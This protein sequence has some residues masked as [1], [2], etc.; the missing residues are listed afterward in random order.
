MASVRT[1]PKISNQNLQNKLQKGW[2]CW[3]WKMP[4]KTTAQKSILWYG[5][6]KEMNVF[7]KVV[8]NQSCTILL[9]LRVIALYDMSTTLPTVSPK[10]NETKLSLKP[11]TFNDFSSKC[12][13]KEK[14]R[15]CIIKNFWIYPSCIL[16]SWRTSIG[17]EKPLCIN[18]SSYFINIW[19]ITAFFMAY[20]NENDK[21]N[22]ISCT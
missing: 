12:L 3:K 11:I 14:K 7:Q 10:P 21:G 13:Q 1:L 6:V 2:S 5:L 15:K 9:Y 17:I 4:Q 18:I 22:L 16:T 8:N 20:C 19:S